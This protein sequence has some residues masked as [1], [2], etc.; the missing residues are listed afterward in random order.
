V[1]RPLR[2][3]WS[4]KPLMGVEV[5]REVVAAV[6][7]TASRLAAMGHHLVEES[8]EFDGLQAL[9]HM[10]DV[11]FF[12]FNLR[13]DGY[14][15]RSGHVIG[16]DTL[17]PITFKIY[18][19]ATRMTATQFLAALAGI[20]SARRQLARYFIQH[21][22]WLCPTT[23]RVAEPWGSYNLGRTD[24]EVVDLAEK[25]LRGPCQFTLPHNILGIPAISL[26]LAIH[27]GGLPIGVQLGSGPATE[28]VLLQLAS[29]LEAQSGWAARIPPLHVSHAAVQN[30]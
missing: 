11:W 14:S 20:N 12:G 6:E 28:H 7:H 4:T 21:D 30:P 24:V 2:I 22:V 18:E 9:R 1:L 8:P 29:A 10:T 15:A 25:V 5:D 16:P 27:S 3:G 26:P 17:E 23:S 13:L 19:H